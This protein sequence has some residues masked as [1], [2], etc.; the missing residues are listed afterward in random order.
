MKLRILIVNNNIKIKYNIKKKKKKIIKIQ[1]SFFSFLT[2]VVFF[3]D[4]KLLIGLSSSESS[5][6]T[7]AVVVWVLVTVTLLAAVGVCVLVVVVVVVAV[8]VAVGVVVVSIFVSV[9]FSTLSP[10]GVAVL[11]LLDA[12]VVADGLVVVFEVEAGLLVAGFGVAAFGAAGLGVVVAGLAAAVLGVVGAFLKFLM[13]VSS[14]SS[15]SMALGLGTLGFAVVV[16]PFALFI[17]LTPLDAA[18]FS[19]AAEGPVPSALVVSITARMT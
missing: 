5:A 14:S 18:C 1:S 9:V 13:G 7:G 10:L 17:L 11:V 3:S 4:V 8:L 2:T 6:L 12:G 15:S 19:A 16:G